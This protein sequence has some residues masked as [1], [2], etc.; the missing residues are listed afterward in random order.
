MKRLVIVPARMGSKRLARK[1]LIEL[2][3][4]PLIEYT[5]GIALRCFD[6]VIVSSESDDLLNSLVL[7]PELDAIKRPEY[8]STDESKVIETVKY[9]FYQNNTGNFDQIWLCLPTCPLR[10]ESDIYNGQ[11]SLT[12][13]IDGVVSITD[14]EFPPNLGLIEDKYGLLEGYSKDHPFANGNSR[15]QDQPKVYR[16]NGAFYGMWW[17]SFKKLENFYR[18][19][20]KGVYMP[21]IRSID[22]DEEIDLILAEAALKHLNNKQLKN[23]N[24]ESLSSSERQKGND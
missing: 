24:D 12:A 16:P 11:R 15:S 8:L 19:Q 3:G 21:R 18:G 13:Q 6:K 20:I 1:N 17:E 22:I 4:K 7:S 14:F 5:I 9:H 23:N 10:S 2:G